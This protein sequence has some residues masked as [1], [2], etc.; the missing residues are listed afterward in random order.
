MSGFNVEET[1]TDPFLH[2]VLNTSRL[3]REQCDTLIN[4]AEAHP[5]QSGQPPSNTVKL[6]L[7]KEQKRLTSHL[8]LLRG[9]NREA[10][11]SARQTRQETAEARQEVDKLHLQLQNLYYEQKHLI[12]EIA[13]CEAF[14]FVSE[15]SSNPRVLLISYSHNY[16]KLPM[17]P[18]E[19]FLQKFPDHRDD[20]EDALMRARIGYEHTEREALEQTRQGLLKRKQGLISE[21]KKR[22]DDLANL[23]QDLEKFVDAAKPIQKTFEKEY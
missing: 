23:D 6:Q 18:L 9:Q 17:I 21:N 19:E 20:G 2:S 13:A 14:E 10:V 15:D 22:K 16:L 1:V 3:T 7:S 8:A 4:L 5:S 12:G 11:L